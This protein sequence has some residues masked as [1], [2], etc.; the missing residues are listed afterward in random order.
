LARETALATLFTGRFV[1][2]AFESEALFS[3]LT[4][5]V[6][7]Q[8]TDEPSSPKMLTM[9]IQRDICRILSP[10]T[11]PLAFLARLFKPTDGNSVPTAP[12]ILDAVPV[13]ARWLYE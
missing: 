3:L 12:T 2:P 10:I 6:V 9:P 11:L 1:V 5:H 4:Y 7:A 13:N 8:H